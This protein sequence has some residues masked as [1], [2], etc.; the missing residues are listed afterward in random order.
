[1]LDIDLLQSF[2]AVVEARS[3]TRAAKR[4]HRTQSTV[5]QQIRKLELIFGAA[6]LKRTTAAGQISLTEDGEALLQ[7]SQR[8]LKLA[9]EAEYVVGKRKSPKAIVRLGL[10]EDFKAEHLTD[11]LANF[12]SEFPDI[13][14]DTVCGL[15]A[16]V[17]PLLR[18]SELDLA[19]MKREVGSGPC[20]KSWPEELVWVGSR[21]NAARADIE[22]I[23]LAVFPQG[24]LYRERAIHALE[25]QG[26]QWRI[27]YASA[28]L[29]GTL[30]AVSSGLAVTL[31]ARTAVPDDLCILNGSSGFPDVP[32]TELALV[33]SEIR[34]FPAQDQ[35]GR[36][37]CNSMQTQHSNKRSSPINPSA[38]P[39]PQ[40]GRG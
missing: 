2:V 32:P 29:T 25:V 40:A 1:M 13:R 23:P 19:L 9:R 33:V 21:K 14:V 10:P 38:L 15:T 30:A 36:Y 26:R 34:T 22:P 4:V 5:S 11:L 3:F 24:C 27:A 17:E 20:L 6:L 7:Y 16:E 31:L 35:L 37:I 18:L 8:I 28:S 12:G 39:L